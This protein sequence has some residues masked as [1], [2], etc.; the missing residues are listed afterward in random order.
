MRTTSRLVSGVAALSLIM[1]AAC[2]GNDDANVSADATAPADTSNGARPEKIGVYPDPRGASYD[3]V[4][5]DFAAGR[6][7]ELNDPRTVAQAYLTDS[8]TRAVNAPVEVTIAETPD[9]AIPEYEMYQF[10]AASKATKIAPGTVELERYKGQGFWYVSA[11]RSNDIHALDADSDDKG[12]QISAA[13]ETNDPSGTAEVQ[14][15][16]L[17]DPAV[18]GAK[19]VQVVN[20]QGIDSPSKH[21]DRNGTL[22]RI[23]FTDDG[24]EV[25]I[26][27]GL[28]R[29]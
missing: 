11:A 8:L 16:G 12:N 29:G 18:P 21:K 13:V 28:Q 6:R 15:D 20:G 19:R 26:F 17:T 22:Y 24:G 25:S 10:T 1:S 9:V 27:E 14:Y 5:A 4:E 7:S 23:V 3:T 2:G